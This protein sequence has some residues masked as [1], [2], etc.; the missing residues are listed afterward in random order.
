MMMHMNYG[1][2][3]GVR[4]ISEENAKAMQTPVWM[5]KGNGDEQYGLCLKEFTDFIDD[6][7]YNVAGSYPV[8][9]TGGAYGLNSIMT[10]SPADGWG[11]VAM[12]NGYTS[13]KGKSFLKTLTNAI[14]NA[15]IKE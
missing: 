10:W 14:Y 12:T 5:E 8:G 1:E 4:V 3:N 2:Y 9:H 7:K 11:I 6:P 13:V 15:H